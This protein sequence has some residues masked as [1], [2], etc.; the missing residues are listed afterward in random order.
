MEITNDTV[1]R[2]GHTACVPRDVILVRSSSKVGVG[3]YGQARGAAGGTLALERGGE[4]SGQYCHEC[5]EIVTLHRDEYQGCA[6]QYV[7]VCRANRV[8]RVSVSPFLLAVVHWTGFE[9]R[10]TAA[11]EIVLGPG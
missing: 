6:V 8:I 1:K 9:I 2:V 10:S 5:A 7:G 4:A 3:P 11:R